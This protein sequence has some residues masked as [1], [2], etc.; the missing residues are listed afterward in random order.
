M[1]HIRGWDLVLEARSSKWVLFLTS[2]PGLRVVTREVGVDH[3]V[4]PCWSSAGIG[5]EIDW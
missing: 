2:S 1:C 5:S 3:P 4:R